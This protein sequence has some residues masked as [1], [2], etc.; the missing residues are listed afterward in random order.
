MDMFDGLFRFLTG[1][2]DGRQSGGQDA[3]AFALAI[4]LIEV[5][6]SDDR[7]EARE[8]SIIE[9][10]LARRFGLDHGEVTRL[11]QA[12]E[13]GAN[14]ATDLHHF[15]QVVVRNFNEDERIGVIEMLWD[16]AYSDRV[17][18]GDED[19]LI[20]RVAGLIYVSDRDRGEAKRR[21]TQRLD[22]NRC[23]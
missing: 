15:T 17:L 8:Q 13:E 10:A 20:R 2:D 3:A 21:V 7:R 1:I 23:P 14:K 18:T 16:V 9:R 12:A 4:L 22:A 19:A 5:A 6:R 11:M